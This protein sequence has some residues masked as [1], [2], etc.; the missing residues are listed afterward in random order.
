[1]RTFFMLVSTGLAAAT[2]TCAAHADDTFNAK[3]YAACVTHIS[4]HIAAE[5]GTQLTFA[6]VEDSISI[7][8]EYEVMISFPY[9]AISGLVYDAPNEMTLVDKPVGSCIATPGKDEF[10]RIVVDG[11]VV[12]HGTVPFDMEHAESHHH[13]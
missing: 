10:T 12:S 7:D 6:P 4:H 8:D 9:G 5:D 11:K 2:L 13:Q 1:M 3:A